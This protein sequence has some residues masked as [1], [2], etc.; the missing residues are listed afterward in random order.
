MTT[1]L[2]LQTKIRTDPSSHA[3]TQL[4]KINIVESYDD[5]QDE[6]VP[7]YLIQTPRLNYMS[8]YQCVSAISKSAHLAEH[9]NIGYTVITKNNTGLDF[10][11]P[12]YITPIVAKHYETNY[13][14]QTPSGVLLPSFTD[15]D[16][17]KQQFITE[18]TQSGKTYG[19]ICD[20]VKLYI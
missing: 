15:S 11:T 1:P 13:C 16:H 18:A 8:F 2:N 12:D 6:Y 3:I 7:P 19:E 4:N 5:Y 10:N 14:K 9:Y 20:D 17:L